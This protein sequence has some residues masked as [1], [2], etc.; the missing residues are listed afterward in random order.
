[1]GKETLFSEDFDKGIEGE[2]V[3]VLQLMKDFKSNMQWVVANETSGNKIVLMGT[4]LKYLGID[5]TWPSSTTE[6]S[7][8]Q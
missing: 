7:R 3:W 1:M 2:C 6:R 5:E 4:K 8:D